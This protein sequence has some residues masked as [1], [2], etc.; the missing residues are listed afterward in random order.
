MSQKTNISD[1]ATSVYHMVI[2]SIYIATIMKSTG[3]VNDHM[4]KLSVLRRLQTWDW[5]SFTLLKTMAI[6]FRS[7]LFYLQLMFLNGHPDWQRRLW[8]KQV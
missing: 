6:Q 1:L 5:A 8:A 2:S 3:T 7:M 4:P